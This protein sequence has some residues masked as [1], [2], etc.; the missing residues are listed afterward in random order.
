MEDVKMDK[1]I[2]LL[3]THIHNRN[4]EK[5]LSLIQNHPE[6]INLE[7]ENG[8]SGLMLLAYSGFKDAFT[9]AVLL[10]TSF[11]F[12]EAIVCGKKEIV[13]QFLEQSESDW[14]NT[15]SKDGFVPLSLAAFFDQTDIALLLL[16]NGA[17]PNL[18]AT[19][20]TKVNALHSAV[21]KENYKL[22]KILLEKGA[23]VNA[24]QMQ[25]VTALHSAV[26]RGNLELTKLLIE[27][28]ANPSLIMDNGDTVLIIANR[29]GHG[30]VEAYLLEHQNRCYF[31]IG[32]LPE[33]R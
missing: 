32:D 2:E 17:D 1:L 10:K 21:A 9:E 18:A 5:A 24:S 8:S 13:E 20:P 3:K 22:C 6:V 31:R 4:A 16:D 28:G 25:N 33:K 19:N 30:L 12:H 15:H 29:E 11:S 7:D 14:P 26:H 27:N 23:N